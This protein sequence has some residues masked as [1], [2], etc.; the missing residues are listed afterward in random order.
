MHS[1]PTA[2]GQLLGYVVTVD[3]QAKGKIIELGWLF[4]LYMALLAVCATLYPFH[5]LHML[6]G[7]H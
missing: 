4:I 7:F 5:L 2:L 6:L 3:S 1:G